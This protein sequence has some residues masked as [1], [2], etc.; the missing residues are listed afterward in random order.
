VHHKY[1]LRPPTGQPALSQFTRPQIHQIADQLLRLR[2]ESDA[3]HPMPLEVSY[4]AHVVMRQNPPERFCGPLVGQGTPQL[5]VDPCH[6]RLEVR[7]EG[8]G[9]GDT[10][11]LHSVMLGFT[12]HEATE[13]QQERQSGGVAFQLGF[14]SSEVLWQR[15]IRQLGVQ[16]FHK[17]HK[18]RSPV[19]GQ[20]HD[21]RTGA[22]APRAH[23][24]PRVATGPR[25]PGYSP[26][27]S[28]L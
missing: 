2:G 3:R 8:G 16:A 24:P 4:G 11:R 23:S 7:D 28:L 9:G 12:G 19:R 18:G 21:D 1:P 6:V 27:W 22:M 26:P 14:R 10:V 20:G 15:G 13:M 5:R 25:G 17:L